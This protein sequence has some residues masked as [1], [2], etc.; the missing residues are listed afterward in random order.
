[1]TDAEVPF[2]RALIRLGVV[3]IVRGGDGQHTSAVLD[4]L[5]GAGLTCAEV[6]LN[7]SGAL[8]EIAAAR[9][10]FGAAAAV[11]AGT[12]R[13]ARDAETALDA[14]AQFLVSPHVC[15]DV[16]R[17]AVQRDAP[18]LPGAFTP[19]EIVTAW[20]AGASAVKVFP[21]GL[22]G[23]RY[24]HDVRGPLDEI[25]LVPTGGVSAAN[26]GEF[27]ASGAIAVGAGGWLIGDALAGG[28]V[29]AL[30]DRAA[31]LVAAVRS[32]RRG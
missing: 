12:V 2:S 24:I 16:A 32:A 29:G 22:G 9:R 1:M 27:I 11:G 21:A 7:T 10:R 4:A 3:A 28:D 6:T 18:Y 23:P 13:S 31:A 15:P 30:A 17:V 5:I 25:P 19:T 8:D 20:E 14:G 26:A